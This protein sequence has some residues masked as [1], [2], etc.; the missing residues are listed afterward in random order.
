MCLVQCG[1]G[2]GVSDPG[3]IW[4]YQAAIGRS[5]KLLHANRKHQASRVVCSWQVHCVNA[6]RMGSSNLSCP[7]WKL[8]HVHL[9]YSGHVTSHGVWT[10][11][12]IPQGSCW[13]VS[14]SSWWKSNGRKLFFWREL[15]V[16]WEYPQFY[17]ELCKWVDLIWCTNTKPWLEKYILQVHH[18]HLFQKLWQQTGWNMHYRWAV[19]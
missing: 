11:K 7:P 16:T 17:G 15:M 18:V 19:F 9:S 8:A 10:V 12:H 1:A 4:D 2:C 5:N 3:Y 6:F 14:E 13:E